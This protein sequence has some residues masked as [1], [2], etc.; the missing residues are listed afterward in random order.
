MKTTEIVL[1]NSVHDLEFGNH[2]NLP[3]QVPAIDGKLF[4][5]F[6]N[7]ERAGRG[8]A[9]L[10]SPGVKGRGRRTRSSKVSWATV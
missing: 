6:T 2:L 3:T 5:A 10:G 9:R 4:T 8:A 1:L 7:D